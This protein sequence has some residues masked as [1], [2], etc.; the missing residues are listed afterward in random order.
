MSVNIEAIGAVRMIIAVSNEKGGVG[1]TTTTLNLGAAIQR[2]GKTVQLWDLDDK[3]ANLSSYA[4]A[5]GIPCRT[6]TGPQLAS[7]IAKYPADYHVID[8]SPRAESAVIFAYQLAD[9]LI[10]PVLCE[11]F[12][13]DGT[14]AILDTIRDVK[15]KAE[16][17]LDVRVLISMY[18]APFKEERDALQSLDTLTL[19]KTVVPRLAQFPKAVGA[20]KSIFDYEGGTR[21][22]RVFASIAKEVME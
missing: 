6:T 15:S 14:V 20:G 16:K 2:A 19:C 18:S 12:A 4:T 9:I 21:G 22:A 10:I 1:K 17:G 7:D 3:Q 13:V 11:Q 5:C 8:C